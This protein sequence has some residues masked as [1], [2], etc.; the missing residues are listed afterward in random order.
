MKAMLA[1]VEP[2]SSA[3]DMVGQVIPLKRLE[4]DTTDRSGA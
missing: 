2:E 3:S 4:A 1:D